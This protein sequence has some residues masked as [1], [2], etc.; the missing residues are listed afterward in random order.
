V[1]KLAIANSLSTAH[2]V[3]LD[4][5][6]HF[7]STPA[8]HQFVA[9]DGRPR[10]TAYSFETHPL[11]GAL[12]RVIDYVGLSDR[13]ALVARF[14][15]TTTPFTFETE[16]VTHMIDAIERQTGRG[17][18]EEFVRSGLTEFFLYSAWSLRD[19]STLDQ[20]FDTDVER[21]PT[22][23]PRRADAAGVQAA[24]E[25]AESTDSA[26]FSVHRRALQSLPPD[27]TA[28]LAQFWFARGLFSSVADGERLVANV[29]DAAHRF[30]REQRWRQLRLKVVGR[31]RRTLARLRP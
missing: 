30:D 7:M 3:V 8:P 25:H 17:F 10:V 23:W 9:Q 20:I 16:R 14:T 12:E 18:A 13:D 11:R 4:A 26:L 21:M 15:S 31:L 29:A 6:N 27:A 28:A 19:G 24:I 22:V 2:Y 1:L 5:K